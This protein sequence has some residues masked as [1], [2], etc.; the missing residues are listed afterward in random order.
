MTMTICA[1]VPV[2]TRMTTG[3]S[4]E[5]KSEM[6]LKLPPMRGPMTMTKDAVFLCN[7]YTEII[8]NE[9]A[10]PTTL[11]PKSRKVGPRQS[12]PTRLKL[13]LCASVERLPRKC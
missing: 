13:V 7:T 1:L 3:F 12:T 9:V 11:T 8:V 6:N 2:A 4:E 10:P 5:W